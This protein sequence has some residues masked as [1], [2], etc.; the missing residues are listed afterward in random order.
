M[1][2]IFSAIQ[3]ELASWIAIGRFLRGLDRYGPNFYKDIDTPPTRELDGAKGGRAAFCR[4]AC[5]VSEIFHIARV[6]N[7]QSH[8]RFF[9]PS[10]DKDQKRLFTELG[11]DSSIAPLGACADRNPS[12]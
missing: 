5:R 3:K 10:V 9:I 6:N 1:I 7:S 4:A 11:S 12:E 8:I 2:D